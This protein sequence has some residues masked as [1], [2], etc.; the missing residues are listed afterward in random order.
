MAGT[1]AVLQTPLAAAADSQTQ[2]PHTA[3][4]ARHGAGLS[5]LGRP[6]AADAVSQSSH[7]RSNAGPSTRHFIMRRSFGAAS[8]AKTYHSATARPRRAI[9][10]PAHRH[11]G[12]AHRRPTRPLLSGPNANSSTR[13]AASSVTWREE[14]TW[15]S[16]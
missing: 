16:V 5:S 13:S 11:G 9:V 7:P 8:I 4:A 6:V 12:D 3:F 1:E 10:A 15:T 2:R 14:P